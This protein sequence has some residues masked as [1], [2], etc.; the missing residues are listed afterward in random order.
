MSSTSLKAAIEVRPATTKADRERFLRL[1][2]RLYRDDPVWV[3]NLLMLQRDL[4][5]EK[6]NPFFDHGEARLFLAWRDGEAAGRISAQIDRRHNEHHG[7]RTGFFGFFESIDDASVASSLLDAAANWLRERGMDTIQGPFSFSIDQEVGMLV[8]GFEHPPMIDTTH[9][10]PY[11]GGLLEQ[12]G[13]AKA[14]DL[15]AYRW[16]VQ[17]M[18]ERIREPID[19]TRA[20]SGLTVRK[21]SMRRLDKEVDILLDIYT[22]AW[23]DNWGFVPVTQRSARKIVD[24]LRLIA[25][26]NVVLIAEIDGEPAGMIVG[27]PNFYEAIRDFK[28]HIDPWKALKLIWRLKVRGTETG[29]ILLYGV[30]Q[31]FQRRRELYG[32]PFLLL[33]ELYKGSQKG[34]Y[35][36]CE[37][38][39]ILESNRRMNAMM[40][41]MG[42]ALYKRYRIYEKA[43]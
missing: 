4:I 23:Q 6:K 9:A 3:P 31:K 40:P 33:D 25:D 24:D 35:K 1:P 5:S 8:E 39:W 15:L 18:P 14:M 41:Y 13:Y 2:W 37:E 42:A 21:I 38:S 12:S 28:G 43:L 34:R 27:V 26:P 29:R 7:E 22:D 17:P 11:Y 30:K 32:L 36:W 10:L 16:D 19:V 20:A